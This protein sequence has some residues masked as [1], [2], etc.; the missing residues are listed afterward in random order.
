MHIQRIVESRRRSPQRAKHARRP[1]ASHALALVIKQRFQT[2]ATQIEFGP[3]MD[4]QGR[5]DARRQIAARRRGNSRDECRRGQFVV[6]HQH[7][8]C[9]ERLDVLRR[10]LDSKHTRK[11]VRHGLTGCNT[12]VLLLG[13]EESKRARHDA[14]N[15]GGRARPLPEAPGRSS[16][17]WRA[18][19]ST[20]SGHSGSRMDRSF[21]T[22]TSVSRASTTSVH[23]SV[24]GGPLPGPKIFR[25]QFKGS[26]VPRQIGRE[27]FA[28]ARPIRR[29]FGDRRFEHRLA[30]IHRTRRRGPVAG[31]R[32]AARLE[33][34]DVFAIVVAGAM[35]RLHPPADRAHG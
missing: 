23:F 21:R 25:H 26:I 24:R 31:A 20:A 14:E 35:T 27:T 6:R 32:D 8:R 30:P 10:R 19:R 17:S 33:P 3:E 9:V 15:G 22:P 1:P 2:V 7:K 29:D 11:P 5:Q 34:I 18:R 28:I 13:T 12:C 4:L 16:M